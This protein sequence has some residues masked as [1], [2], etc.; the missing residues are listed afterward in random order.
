MRPCQIVTNVLK[1]LVLISLLTLLWM[2]YK[3][4]VNQPQPLDHTFSSSGQE[5]SWCVLRTF[6]RVG[7]WTAP[8]HHL[9]ASERVPVGYSHA[10]MSM[11]LEFPPGKTS[12]G[13]GHLPPG[14]SQ[15]LPL[16]VPQLW[17]TAALGNP[18][19][20]CTPS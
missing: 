11:V 6:S 18:G 9:A 16:S 10:H 5:F 3:Q 13:S 4:F 1:S 7:T 8:G 14:L 19:R 15:P 17:E 20:V 12:Q 2:G